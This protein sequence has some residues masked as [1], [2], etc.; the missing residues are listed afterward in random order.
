[1]TELTIELALKTV[2]TKVAPS[3]WG[4]VDDLAAK[5]GCRKSDIVS[6]A[7]LYMPEDEIKAKLDAQAAAIDELPKAVRGLLRHM[8]KLDAAQR[9]VVI[10]ALSDPSAK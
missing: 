2:S 3:A 6:I 9:K 10:D 8:D 1:M 5:F 4:R 7:L